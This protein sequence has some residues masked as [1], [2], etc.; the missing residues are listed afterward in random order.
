MNFEYSRWFAWS[1]YH[2]ILCVCMSVVCGER[3]FIMMRFYKA[4]NVWRSWT[5]YGKEKIIGTKFYQWLWSLCV[6]W[7][8]QIRLW[9][10]W[11]RVSLW[12]RYEQIWTDMS[13]ENGIWRKGK[14][15]GEKSLYDFKETPGKIVL[16]L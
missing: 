10:Q 3:N 4:I 16:S 8:E 6:K 7:L 11:E 15:E 9:S 5:I 12:S 14:E 1:H 2:R 13:N